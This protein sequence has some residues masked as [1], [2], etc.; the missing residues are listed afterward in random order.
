MHTGWRWRYRPLPLKVAPIQRSVTTDL[1]LQSRRDSD[2]QMSEFPNWKSNKR[3]FITIITTV[4]SLWI[5]KLLLQLKPHKASGPDRIP[6]RVLK[7]LAW[8]LAPLLTAL[9]NQ[10]LASGTIPDDWSRALVTPVYKKG[11]V[12]EPSNY[13]PVSLTTVACKTLE[14][15][16][17]KHIVN[18]LE[19]HKLLTTLQ[20]GFRKA[21]SCESQLLITIDDLITAYNSKVQTDVG[22]LDFSRAF[23][24][25]PHERLMGK[26]AHYRIQG[27]TNQWIRAFLTNRSMRVVVDGE[28][29]DPAPVLSG[30]PQGTVLGPLLFLVYINDM[31]NVISEGTFIRLFA[32]DCLVYRRIH[33]LQDQLT[34]QEDLNNLHCWATRWGMN[35]NPSKCYI[36]QIARAKPMMKLYEMCGVILASVDRAKYLGVTVSKNLQWHDQ[37]GTVTKKAN[38]TLHMVARNLRYC[39]RK[40]RTL[41]YCSLVRPK[42]EYCASVWDPHQQQDIESLEKVNR[43]ATRVVYNKS[44]R[45]CNVSPTALLKE[46]GW[47]PLEERRRTQRLCMMYKIVHGLVAVPPTRLVKPNRQLRGHRYKYQHI[48]TNC[49]QSKHSF[50]PRTIREWNSLDANIAEAPSLESFRNRLS[51]P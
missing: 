24:T 36:M 19:R 51:K 11:D 12:H 37:V 3:L 42:L 18:Y 40:S 17:C 13:R 39:P 20:H 14:H 10:S 7:E 8:E 38:S 26:L 27:P 45:D 28:T 50:Y 33:S 2:C 23:D 31:P 1:H 47:P 9:Y 35:F 44:W 49:E 25:V 43:R 4:T 22:I 16:V 21:H 15:I 30:V 46:L 34:L 48:S 5:S 6:N 29:S 32:D 41:A